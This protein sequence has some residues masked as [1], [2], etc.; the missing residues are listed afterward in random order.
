MSKRMSG[1]ALVTAIGV[2]GAYSWTAYAASLEDQQQA[3]DVIVTKAKE[4][5]KVQAAHKDVTGADAV[6]PLRAFPHL[7]QDR[8]AT[9]A[10]VLSICSPEIRA[11]YLGSLQFKNGKLAG[12]YIG[13]I[14]KCLSDRQID[15]LFEH[16]GVRATEFLKF[17]KC[18]A[19]G[20]CTKSQNDACTSN[21]RS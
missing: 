16:Q 12:A 20:N 13:G 21:C 5:A 6:A 7:A 14:D 18:T 4:L 1:W 19:R 10:E 9:M 8:V 11:E 17:Y 3:A 2:V 15:A